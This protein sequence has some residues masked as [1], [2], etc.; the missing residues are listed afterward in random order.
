ML[1]VTFYSSDKTEGRAG[2]IAT[3][4]AVRNCSKEARVVVG[5][6][7]Q[8]GWKSGYTGVFATK[9]SFC[10]T[11]RLLLK[12][13]KKNRY[14]R[15]RN[16]VLFHA[17][18]DAGVRAH[19]HRPS[20]TC[21]GCLGPGP[22]LSHLESPQGSSSRG[23]CS[24]WRLAVGLLFVSCVP[25]GVTPGLLV[26]MAATS[27]FPKGQA[28]FK[29]TC[30][31]SLHSSLQHHHGISSCILYKKKKEMRPWE[32]GYPAQAWTFRRPFYMRP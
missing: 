16:W 9:I 19:W 14:L 12:K 3:Q 21:L 22:V 30:V 7:G 31:I 25:S 26:A 11:K 24:R 1:R 29:F 27:L 20:D 18:E 4:I 6:R 8:G 13:K 32:A 23:G 2:D 5:N 15:L 17:W 28:F 10:N